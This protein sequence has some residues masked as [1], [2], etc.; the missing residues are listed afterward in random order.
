MHRFTLRKYLAHGL[1]C[2]R[3]HMVVVHDRLAD[4]L[5]KLVSVV[6]LPQQGQQVASSSLYWFLGRTQLLDDL[7]KD[8]TKG[9]GQE[10]RRREVQVLLT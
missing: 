6:A 5:C 7:D 8:E 10:A 3:A 2:G 9:G 1:H 4:H